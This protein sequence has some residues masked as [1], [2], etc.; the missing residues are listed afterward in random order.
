MTIKVK[1]IM[2]RFNVS[3]DKVKQI[4]SMQLFLVDSYQCGRILVSYTTIIGV[5]DIDKW[6][7]TSDRYS[8]TTTRQ[9]NKFIKSTPFEVE[10]VTEDNLRDM[11]NFRYRG[12]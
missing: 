1:D 6:Y 2:K 7:I 9:T 3:K 8:S 10:R 5:F 11:V 12:Y 4:D